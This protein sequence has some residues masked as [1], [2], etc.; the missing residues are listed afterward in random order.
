MPGQLIRLNSAALVPS[1]HPLNKTKKG[2]L[3]GTFFCLLPYSSNGK[4][5]FSLPIK[6]N[7]I[8]LSENIRTKCK[9]TGPSPHIVAFIP[10]FGVKSK[11][12]IPQ[13]KILISETKKARA[14]RFQSMMDKNNWSR[15]D[16]ARHL[17]V[18]RAWISVA[19]K[20]LANDLRGQPLIDR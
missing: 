1:T 9:A 18:S 14:Q 5:T 3:G 16:L 10:S 7:R 4:N 19:L 15:A 6:I 13:K 12:N 8:S 11:K 17:S 2:S 20:P